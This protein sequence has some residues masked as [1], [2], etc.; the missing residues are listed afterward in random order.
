LGVGLAVVTVELVSRTGITGMP[1]MELV[2]VD[3]PV[4]LGTM[5]LATVVGVGTALAPALALRSGHVRASLAAR[6]TDP[7]GP[8][9]GAGRAGLVVSQVSLSVLLLVGAGLVARSLEQIFAEDLGFGTADVLT[10]RVE[11][12]GYAGEEWPRLAL[13][14]VRR[15]EALPGVASAGVVEPLPLSGRDRSQRFWIEGRPFTGSADLERADYAPATRGYFESLGIPLIAGRHFGS[16]DDG[17]PSVVLVSR[18]TAERFWP[19][20]DALGKTVISGGPDSGNPPLAVVGIVG[21]VRH[22][23]VRAPAPNQIY[24]HYPQLPLGGTVVLRAARGRVDELAPAIRRAVAEVDPSVPIFDLNTLDALFARSIRDE[25]SV[26]WGLGFFGVYAV[27]ERATSRRMREMAIRAAFGAGRATLF[28]D[29]LRGAMSPVALG[30]AIGLAAALALSRIVES[31]LF[32]IVPSDPATYGLVALGVAAAA[33]IAS[34][35]PSL[36]VTT[37]DPATALR[38]G[39]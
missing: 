8:G 10:F 15:L 35:G 6:A 21:D 4:A 3:L 20:E 34:I 19:G 12:S 28:R 39:G 31:L 9:R 7:L 32:G 5:L 1:R 18:S 2:T 36:R 27:V 25:R 29:V 38:D 37:T 17:S 14:M 26:A 13:D 24:F 23:G 11:H 33:L 16:T 22:Y 30:I